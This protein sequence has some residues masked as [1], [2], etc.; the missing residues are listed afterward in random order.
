M[1]KT[2][3]IIAISMILATLIFSCGG[4]GGGGGEGDE[5]YYTITYDANGATSGS[6]PASQKVLAGDRI[7]VRANTG[8]LKKDGYLFD[9]WYT[10]G[11]RI[12]EGEEIFI[13]SDNRTLYAKWV[14]LP[15]MVSIPAQSYMLSNT[16]VTWE[17]YRAV[18]G[19][20]RSISFWDPVVDTDDLE[21]CPRS[22]DWYEAISFCNDLSEKVGLTP[23][24]TISGNI[25]TQNLLA[26][27]FRLPTEDE[28]E[29]A[30]RGGEAYIYAGSDNIDE[31]AWYLN[32]VTVLMGFHPVAEKKANG[33]G[34]Y[35]MSGN[36][37]E[38][39]WDVDPLDSNRRYLR[40]G[41]VAHLEEG[42]RVT[43]RES[44][45]ADSYGDLGSWVGHGFRIARK[46]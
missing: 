27:G 28:W 18:T 19:D 15:T 6:V 8:N 31:V 38:W 9:G 32:N 7:K 5:N 30:A 24:Y 23:V 34:L 26:D 22:V 20:E 16:E 4:G 39:C 3:N 42:C 21:R 14:S 1:K 46:K 33:Y 25:V 17:L 45:R 37:L 44:W 10:S 13:G 12:P 29:Y 35:D 11:G 40:G 2:A 36:E 41:S 43:Y